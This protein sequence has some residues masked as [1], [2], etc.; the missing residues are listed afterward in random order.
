MYSEK[1]LKTLKLLT[2]PFFVMLQVFFYTKSTQRKIGHSSGTPTA[3]Q[4]DFKG[5]LRSLQ[6]HLNHIQTFDTLA[7]GHS[8][9]L[10]IERALWH[11]GTKG[12]WALGHSRHSRHLGTLFSR[13]GYMLS[14]INM[15]FYVPVFQLLPDS[16]T[17]FQI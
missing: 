14:L 10:G 8:T 2:S 4:V 1:F 5:T 3:L 17:K 12:T 9:H 16:S 13:H 11:F 15:N 7:I 6:E